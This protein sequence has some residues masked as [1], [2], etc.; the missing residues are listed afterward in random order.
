MLAPEIQRIVLL[1]GLAAAGYLLILAWN[2]DY[3]QPEAPIAPTEAPELSGGSSV[4]ENVPRGASGSPGVDSDIPDAS[5]IGAR[6]PEEAG[7]TEESV[8]VPNRLIRVTTPTQDVWIDRLGG[9]VRRVRLPKYPVAL[10]QPDQPFNLLDVGNGRVYMA[11]SGLIG[12]DGL[13]SGSDRPLFEARTDHFQVK[14]GESLELA[15]VAEHHG[16]RVEKV[17]AF[18]GDDYLIDVIYRIRNPFDRPFQASLFAQIKRDA[19]APEGAGGFRMG[20]QPY[21]GAALTTSETRYEKLE[22][23]DLDEGPYRTTERGG[24][25]ALLQHYFLSAWIANQEED[26]TYYGRKRGDGTYT[27]GYTGPLLSVA[28]GATGEWRTRLYAGPK[29]QKRLEQIA[30]NLNLTIDYGF[31]WWLAVPLFWILDWLHSFVHNWG[32]AIILLT[33]LVKLVLYPLSSTS[34]R[35]MA[36]MRRVAPQMKRLQERYAGDRQ[37]LSQEMMGLYKKEGV[38]PLGGCLPMLLPMP[39]FIALY[40]VLFESVEL[41]QAPFLLWIEDLAAKDPFFV[42]P[43]LMGGT[44][45]LQQ[46]M[47]PAMGDPM[48]VR[49]MK[50]MPIVFTVLFLWFPAG[51]VLYWLVNSVLSVAQQWYVM[52]RAEVAAAAKG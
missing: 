21:V 28:P 34:Y 24:W 22:F 25:M 19:K 45:Y 5:L 29:D 43:L 11:Q 47:S 8:A 6:S 18:N 20:P 26:N 51:L 3:M 39:I 40:W 12:P 15:L 16:V 17:F 38:N 4:P 1:V 23:E 50:M 7:R 35:S 36:N 14:P 33:V 31:L 30:E 13:D 49:M 52:N 41:R 27:V 2:E 10:D 37:K 48:Q 46:L 32:V 9:D 44:M 42:L